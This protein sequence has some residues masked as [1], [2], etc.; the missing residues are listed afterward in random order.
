MRQVVYQPRGD[1]AE[2][3]LALLFADVLLELDQPI[4]HRVEGIPE[5]M[6]LVAAAD[7]DPLIHPALGERLR[8][9]GQREDPRDEGARPDPAEQDRPEQ[10]QRDRRHEL[11]L[12]RAGDGIRL[13]GRLFDDDRP[14]DVGHAGDSRELFAVVTVCV[15]L[16]ELRFPVLRHHVDFRERMLRIDGERDQ[17]LLGGVAMRDDLQ[18][19]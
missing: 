12:E 8:R 6:D 4:R 13:V 5:L 9:R 7:R 15:D 19:G 2:H 17:P 3:R 10:R 1:P 16:R 14:V 11:L 18:L